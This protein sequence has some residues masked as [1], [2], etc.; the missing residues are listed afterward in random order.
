MEQLR[1]ERDEAKKEL[2]NA[3]K[4]I[5][6]LKAGG[7]KESMGSGNDDDADAVDGDMVQN[8]VGEGGR[9]G[10]GGGDD[11]DVEGVD[12]SSEIV[13][14]EMDDEYEGGEE[15]LLVYEDGDREEDY[16]QTHNPG[17]TDADTQV[18]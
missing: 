9:E 7:S 5:E 4:A 6:S 8:V 18:S 2:E 11:G 13:G 14:L 15:D 1:R 17:F 3:R 10:G 16:L 12:E